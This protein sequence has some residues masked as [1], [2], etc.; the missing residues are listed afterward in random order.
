MQIVGYARVSTTDQ[1]LTIQ[2]QQLTAAGCSKLFEEK[3]SGAKGD[4]PQLA[5]MLAY[6]RDGDV[7]VITKL[8][9]LARS[10]VHFWSIWQQLETKG[11][12]FRVLDMPSLDTSTSHGM[13]LM[14]VLASVAQFERAMIRERQL[15]GIKAAKAEGVYKGRSQSQ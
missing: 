14:G 3:E 8:D 5:A 11:V 6:V 10:M 9:R 7:L 1:D 2:R 4:R 15:D 13:L 12:S